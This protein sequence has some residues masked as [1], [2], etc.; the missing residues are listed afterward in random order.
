[1]LT[2][3]HSHLYWDA[4]KEDF[5]QMLQRTLDAGV[6]TLINVGVDV[7]KSKEALK[8]VQ[9][10]KWPETLR[11]YSSIGIHPH[12]ALRFASLT[13]DQL[14]DI[15]ESI[16]EDIEQL[17]RV[18]R[19]NTS[20]VVA[21]GECGLDFLFHPDYMKT[22]DGTLLSEDQLKALQRKLFQAQIDLAKNLNLP[23]LV[24]CRDERSKNPNNSEAWTEVLKM[25]GTH[26][27]ILHCYS[28]ISAITNYILQTKNLLVSFSATVTYPKND[29]LLQAVK[30]LPLDKIVL[31][32]DCPFLPPQGKRGQRNESSFM[33]ETAKF[34]SKIKGA[35][36]EELADQTTKNAH[37]LLSL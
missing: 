18:Y 27:A 7:E 35:T 3:T 31:E 30:V 2:D 32:T 33:L 8:Q 21:V 20:K 37:R 34:I 13:Q 15:D 24:H 36:L 23:L 14:S 1:M 16:H 5:N 26:P 22:P 17:G 4:F 10:T 25:I 6:T 12:E 28:G 29:Y 9:N 11:V 19:E